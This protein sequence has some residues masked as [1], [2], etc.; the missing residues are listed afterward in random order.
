MLYY[1]YNTFERSFPMKQPT[2]VTPHPSPEFYDSFDPNSPSNKDT[3]IWSKFLSDSSESA[4]DTQD[5]PEK[6]E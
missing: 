1:L 2:N 6:P 5:S 4:S 3:S